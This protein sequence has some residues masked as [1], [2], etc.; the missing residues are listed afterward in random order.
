M[1]DSYL[2]TSLI[3]VKARKY[4]LT[5]FNAL[6]DLLEDTQHDEHHC[7]GD[8]NCPVEQ[9]RAAVRLV[10]PKALPDPTESPK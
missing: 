9:A 2:P 3:E 8:L 7:G 5:L 6:C 4:A 10:D 1:I